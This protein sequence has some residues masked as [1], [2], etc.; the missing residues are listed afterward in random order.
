MSVWIGL[1]RIEIQE[2]KGREEENLEKIKV[3]SENWTRRPKRGQVIPCKGWKS[4][5]RR[6][7]ASCLLGRMDVG[8]VQYPLVMSMRP[9]RPASSP[10]I[11][12]CPSIKSSSRRSKHGP[13]VPCGASHSRV[14]SPWTGSGRYFKVQFSGE[15]RKVAPPIE[16]TCT[17]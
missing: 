2:Q 1:R 6:A 17:L 8:C 5:N 11:R 3:A 12:P 9:C 15:G 13:Q 7:Y 16:R 4:Q 10:S 14:G